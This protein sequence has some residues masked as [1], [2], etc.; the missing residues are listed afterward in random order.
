MIAAVAPFWRSKSLAEMSPR[1][2]ELVCDGCGKC[3][4]HKLEDEDSGEVFYTDVACRLL[5]LESCQCRDYPR[6][7]ERVPDCLQLRPSDVQQFHWLPESCAYRRLSEGRGLASW[8]PLVSGDDSSVHSAGV[9]VRHRCVSEAQVA[10]EDLEE[11]II[12]WIE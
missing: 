8:H 7:L 1:E 12:N 5:D 9:S 6:R 3:C 10:D 2:W 4:L 11:H